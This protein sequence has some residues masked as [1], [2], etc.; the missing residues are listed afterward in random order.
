MKNLSRMSHAK[1]FTLIELLTVVA[2]IAILSG[3][4]L[5][6]MSGARAKARDAQRVSDLAQLQ[7]AL[8]LFNDRCGQYPTGSLLTTGS[9]ASPCSTAS[10]VINLGTF[11]G[12]IPT[13]PGGGNYGYNRLILGSPSK[14][15]NYILHT[16]L[17]KPSAAGAK[18]LC[19]VDGGGCSPV[20]ITTPT[21]GTWSQSV[22][23]PP[24]ANCSNASDS[25]NYCVG[26]N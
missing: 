6:S 14:N 5:V 15:V 4:I 12:Q 7:L 8:A 20:T 23:G 24:Y 1:G 9:S 18:G 17:E 10:P 2:I 25:V 16:A 26:P 3:I 13:P 11:I 22:T 19:G 21:G